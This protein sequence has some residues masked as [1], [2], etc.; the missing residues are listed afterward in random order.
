MQRPRFVGILLLPALLVQGAEPG[1]KS[2]LDAGAEFSILPAFRVSNEAGT[3]IPLFSL[4]AFRAEFGYLRHNLRTNDLSGPAVITDGWSGNIAE[5]EWPFMA[6]AYFGYAC[7]NLAAADPVIRP[8]ALDEMRWLIEALQ[9]PRLSGFVAPHFGPPF[10]TSQTNVA[11]FVHGHFLNLCLRHREV[12]G[13]SRFDALIQRVAG[14]LQAAFARS[15]SGVLKSYRD[16]WWISDNL[17][18]LS[19][20]ARFDRQFGSNTAPARERFVKITQKHFLDSQTGLFATYVDGENQR[21]LQGP[22]GISTMYGLHFLPDISADFAADQYRRAK[23]EFVRELFG[24]AAVR[25]FPERAPGRADI[26]SGPLVLGFGPSA[27]GFAIAAAAV[28]GDKALAEALL[29]S[30]ALTGLPEWKGDMLSYAAMPPVG[31]AV[32]LF[33]KSELLKSARR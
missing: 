6:F 8:D 29:R 3:A 17:P 12:S 28:N 13:D 23:R 31:Q 5:A 14:G 15:D 1:G 2:Q 24:L 25:E 30:V 9:T 11:V 10:G 18:A 27:S 22:R 21:P 4:Q 26:D 7:A 19:A 16:M 32:I 20:L 33:G